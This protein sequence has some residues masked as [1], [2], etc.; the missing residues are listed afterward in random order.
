MRDRAFKA[1]HE[2]PY[3]APSLRTLA[4]AKAALQLK[5]SRTPLQ[6]AVQILMHRPQAGERAFHAR[7][8]Y[9][10]S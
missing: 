7:L 9:D 5:R 8:P 3:L 1:G 2:V 4:L 10:G 6:A